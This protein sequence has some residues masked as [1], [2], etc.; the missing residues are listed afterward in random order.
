M[1][2]YEG[3]ALLALPLSARGDITGSNQIIW[4]AKRGTP[5]IPSPVFYDRLLFYTQSNQALLTC[6]D[7]SNGRIMLDR[8]CLRALPNVYASLVG[9]AGRVYMPGRKGTTLVLKRGREFE[10]LATNKLNDSIS[11][12]PAL[13][14]DQ[15]FLRGEQFLYCLAKTF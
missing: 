14:G 10:V 8:E 1:T 5:Y 13:T 7:A 4:S 9:A 12:S 6:A 3:H 15:L 11:A 2:G